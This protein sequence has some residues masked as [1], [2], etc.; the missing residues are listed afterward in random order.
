M[1]FLTH[2]SAFPDRFY[3]PHKEQYGMPTRHISHESFDDILSELGDDPAIPD[4]HG[5]RRTLPSQRAV[6]ETPIQA[7]PI[8]TQWAWL[9][10]T[11]PKSLFLIIQTGIF[12][13]LF[14][15]VFIGIDAYKKELGIEMQGLQDQLL[16]L[17]K[18]L[19]RHQE[20]WDEEQ[21]DLYSA[22][23]KLEVSIHSN[24]KKPAIS[25]LQRLPATAPHE[26]ELR[27]WRY[28]GLIQMNG[29]EQAF[30]HTGKNTM[31]ASKE[32]VVLGDW[33]LVH[34]QKDMATLTHPQGKSLH[35]KAARSE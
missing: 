35:F 5:I 34:A 6:S 20:N 12:L 27:R 15:M 9:N 1:T 21:D 22:L 16:T 11:Q 8:S 24:I 10:F 7:K 33:R 32:V 30:F 3:Y 19:S 23:D 25:P 29:L 31:M 2:F 26:A 13:G 17:N 28:L 14:G 18:E 4:P